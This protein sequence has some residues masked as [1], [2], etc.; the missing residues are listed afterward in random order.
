MEPC[1]GCDEKPA[2]DRG[3]AG[4]LCNNC[5]GQLHDQGLVVPLYEGGYADIDATA[6]H[7][8]MIKSRVLRDAA[9]H[10]LWNADPAQLTSVGSHR[11]LTA[12]VRLDL[13]TLLDAVYVASHLPYPSNGWERVATADLPGLLE[14]VLKGP[15]PTNLKVLGEVLAKVKDLVASGK[16]VLLIAVPRQWT[17]ELGIFT[18]SEKSS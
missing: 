7:P 3:P 5:L 14:I 6:D 11:I 15:Y 16:W 13:A 17:Y 12:G 8:Y 9:F 18:K 2:L 4:H 10:V 1:E